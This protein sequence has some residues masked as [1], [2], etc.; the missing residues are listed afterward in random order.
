MSL[1]NRTHRGLNLKCIHRIP[2]VIEKGLSM[3]TYEYK[4]R[5]CEH[6][7]EEFQSMSDDPLT[8]CPS[9]GKKSLQRL[10]GTGAAVIFKGSGFYET[11]YKS[12]TGS[13]SG[14]KETDTHKGTSE[15]AS[16]DTGTDTEMPS[17]DSSE[18]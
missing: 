4:C 10:I 3:P 11:D 1:L 16:A 13:G 17:A 14:K 15:G 9:C 12:K 5:T 6:L 2:E 7:F 18:D 8:T